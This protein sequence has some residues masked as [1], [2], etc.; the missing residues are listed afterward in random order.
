MASEEVRRRAIL[1]ARQVSHSVPWARA[2]EQP[3]PHIHMQEK[4]DEQG[5][6]AIFDGSI[7][8]TV[9]VSVSSGHIRATVTSRSTTARRVPFK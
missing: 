6:S 3:I 5:L 1:L 4:V 8:L 2:N 9:N 7:A